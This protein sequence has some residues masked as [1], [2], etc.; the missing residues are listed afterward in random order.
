MWGREL[1]DQ[2]ISFR[3]QALEISKWDKRLIE[4]SDKV[5]SFFFRSFSHVLTLCY[6]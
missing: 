5:S 3:K 4:N 2:T 6:V 1:E